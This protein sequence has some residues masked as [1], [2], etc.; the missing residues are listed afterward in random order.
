MDISKWAFRKLT[1]KDVDTFSQWGTHTDPR[2]FQYNFPYLEATDYDAWYASKQC[3]LSRKVYGLFEGDAAIAFVTLKEIRWLRGTAELGIAV[4]PNR[5]SEGIGT[6]LLHR[7][8][9]YVFR[10]FPIRRLTLRVAHFNTRAQRAYEKVGFKRVEQVTE[11][12]E[13]QRY[14]KTVYALYPDDFEM[15]RG[16]LYTRFWIMEYVRASK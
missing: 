4:D 8:I 14:K 5:L 12:F 9:E 6:E 10:R 13:E 11:P 1:R 2:Y 15:R 3:L 7:Y 16:V